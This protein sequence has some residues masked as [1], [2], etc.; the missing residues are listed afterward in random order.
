MTELHSFTCT[1]KA[2]S[3]FIRTDKAQNWKSAAE[4]NDGESCYMSTMQILRIVNLAV[5]LYFVCVFQP[6]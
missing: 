4:K 6:E 2:L 3:D 1:V 5:R